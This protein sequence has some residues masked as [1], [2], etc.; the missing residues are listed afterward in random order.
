VQAFCHWATD[1]HVDELREILADKDASLFNV[2]RAV[3]AQLASLNKPELYQDIIE[4]MHEL[5]LR[6]ECKKVLIAA[7]SPAED[8]VL[9]G[10]ESSSDEHV[11]RE[12]VEVLQKIG[13]KKSVAKLEAIQS[14]GNNLLKYS[15][16]RALDAIRARL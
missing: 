8:A 7:G 4:A 16:D 1:E 11:K 2:R 9:T 15:A 6:H 13:T 5:S 3:L 10:L 12:L 14:S